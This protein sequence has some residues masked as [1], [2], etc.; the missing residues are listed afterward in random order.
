[1]HKQVEMLP[2]KLLKDRLSSLRNLKV[3]KHDGMEPSNLFN[4]RR[5]ALRSFKSQ[6]TAIRLKQKER[7]V[8][9]LYGLIRRMEVHT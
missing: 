2:P 3:H 6:I 7:K 1:M 9:Y 8:Y 4:D 5:K